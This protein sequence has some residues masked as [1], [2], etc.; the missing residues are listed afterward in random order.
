MGIIHSGHINTCSLTLN[1]LEFVHEHAN[2]KI[3]KGRNHPDRVM[4][5]KHPEERSLERSTDTGNAVNRGIEGAEGLAAVVAGQDAHVIVEADS[6]LDH[7]IHRRRTHIRMKVAEV[8][9]AASMEF[10]RQSC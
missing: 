3:F 7:P 1:H 8:E 10:A 5:A 6:K 2:A 4:I 9:D